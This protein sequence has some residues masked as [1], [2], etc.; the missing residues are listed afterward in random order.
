[1]ILSRSFVIS[2]V[3]KVRAKYQNPNFEAIIIYD[4]QKFH[5]FWIFL[6]IVPNK[7]VALSSFNLNR[8]ISSNRSS[9]VF[10]GQWNSINEKFKNRNEITVELENLRNI[11]QS[12]MNYKKLTTCGKSIPSEMMVKWYREIMLSSIRKRIERT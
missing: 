9:K 6:T 10:L 11:T 12:L 5:I 2:Y 3:I 7:I 1:M 4:R 8:Y